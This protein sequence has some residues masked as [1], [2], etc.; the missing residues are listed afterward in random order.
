VK[1]KLTPAALAALRGLKPAQLRA[2]FAAVR[3]A[4]DDPLI[5]AVH[6]PAPAKSARAA[7]PLAQQVQTLLRP[8]LAN[9]AEKAAYLDARM[10]AATGLTRPPGGGLAQAVRFWAKMAGAETVHA[11]AQALMDSLAAESRR[12]SIP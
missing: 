12:E 1:V 2:L 7:D 6:P 8:I 10:E 3:A 5:A 11:Q 4:P 9:S